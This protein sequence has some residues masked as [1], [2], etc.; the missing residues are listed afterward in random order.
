MCGLGPWFPWPRCSSALFSCCSSPP[1]P[2]SGSVWLGLR[3]PR[4]LAGCVLAVAPSPPWAPVL[5]SSGL[6]WPWPGRR[7]GWFPCCA[8][9]PF[10]CCCAPAWR[11]SLLFSGALLHRVLLCCLCCAV[12]PWFVVC[13]VAFPIV[14]LR[15]IASA[16]CHCGVFGLRWWCPHPPPVVARCS[17]SCCV[18][19]WFVVR[20]VWCCAVLGWR[21]CFLLLRRT[22]LCLFVL[23]PAVLRCCVLCFFPW[24]CASL[25]RR[26]PCR[27]ERK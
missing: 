12:R 25:C 14:V 8:P 20:C 17:A 4:A 10:G 2:G 7:G 11:A 9:P 23:S 27:L 19:S 5:L 21:V 18:V 24:C 22:L 3:L 13:C 26:A 6:R 16:G 15:G 1:S